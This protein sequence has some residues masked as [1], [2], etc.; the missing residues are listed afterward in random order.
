M[1]KLVPLNRSIKAGIKAGLECGSKAGEQYEVKATADSRGK[2]GKGKARSLLRNPAWE[3]N[4]S[5]LTEK[6]LEQIF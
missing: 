6:Q 5:D 3:Q 4:I 1:I 2:T